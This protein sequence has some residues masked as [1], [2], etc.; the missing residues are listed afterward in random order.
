MTGRKSTHVIVRSHHP[1]LK[2]ALLLS[3]AL[4]I[5]ASGWLLFEY[6]RKR[7]GFDALEA[8]QHFSALEGQIAAL[9]AENSRLGAEITILEQAGE[10][11]RRAHD[12]VSRSLSELQTELLELRQEVGFYR[13]I[14]NAE[15]EGVSGLKVQALKLRQDSEPGRWHFRL[16]LSQLATT[17]ARIRGHAELA[18]S[19]VMNGTPVELT[20]RQLAGGDA[21]ALQFNL[22]H[23]QEL[24]GNITLPEGF[25]PLR[26][27]LKVT[28]GGNAGAPLER[29]YAWADVVS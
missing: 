29:T 16:I 12:E 21:T 27:L 1:R 4:V 2:Q 13:G 17:N 11:D 28:P 19:G 15:D 8:R 23:F 10:I 7:A 25:L 6:G 14:V 5:V 26:M 3:L 20:H 9:K 18:V 22:R 24:R